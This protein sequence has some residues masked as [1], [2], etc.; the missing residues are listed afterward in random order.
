[1][2]FSFVGSITLDTFNLLDSTQE[3]GMIPFLAIFTLQNPRVHVSASNSCDE[4]T[5]VKTP[6]NKRL[7]FTT[8]L[9]IP[10]IDPNDCHV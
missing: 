6:V 3:C 4:P 2:I 9:D 7:G 10:Y 5:D 1:M 8:T